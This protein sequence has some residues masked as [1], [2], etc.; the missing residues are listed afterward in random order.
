ME[1]L[2]LIDVAEP[3]RIAA[4][5]EAPESFSFR[6]DAAE[7]LDGLVP[8]IGLTGTYPYRSVY[9]PRSFARAGLPATLTH[10]F[11]DTLDGSDDHTG[12]RW[13]GVVMYD[14]HGS[15][16]RLEITL[17]ADPIGCMV[18]FRH[19]N[20]RHL[21]VLDRPV[22]FMGEMEVLRISGS[23]DA[24][25]RLEH[26]VLLKER[27]AAT[28]YQ[29]R[30]GRLTARL[31]RRPDG[32]FAVAVDAI[33]RPAA[34]CCVTVLHGA[35]GAVVGSAQ[36]DEH[37]SL[38]A[39]DLEPVP[40]PPAAGYRARIV[41]DLVLEES[42]WQRA[43]IRYRFG[44][45]DA[46]GTPHLR[47]TIR[48]HVYR[49]R[50]ALRIVHR[51]EVTSPHLPP[52]PG[53]TA[54]A[55]P[56]HAPAIRRAIAGSDGE[57][58]TLL[59]LR[60]GTL[61]ISRGA[62]GAVYWPG[63]AADGTPVAEASAVRLIHDHDQGH[64]VE[65]GD[66]VREVESRVSGHVT[67]TAG[68][69][70]GPEGESLTVALRRF[71]QT[72]PRAVRVSGDEI[73]VELLPPPAPPSP[74]PGDEESWHRIYFWLGEQ[75]YLLKAGMALSSEILLAWGPRDEALLAWFE[76]PPAVRPTLEWL[77]ACNALAPLAAKDTGV[78]DR[79]ERALDAGYEQWIADREIRRQYGWLNFGDWYGESAWSWGNNE[80]D[81]PFAHYC[82]FLRGG[83]PRWFI[84]GAEA[85][86]HLTDVDT[87]NFSTDATQVGA[88]Y[89]HMPGHA[90]GYLPPYFRS[91]M[92][93]SSSVPSHTWVEGSV[94]HYLLTGDE[95]LRESLDRTAQWLIASGLKDY[96][97]GIQHYDFANCRECGW[98]LIH[99]T[100][101]ARMSAAPRYLN[102]AALIV[103]RV[104]TLR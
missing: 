100:A 43:V 13:I 48:V 18:P 1:Q 78:L 35:S 97:G 36:E 26:V 102:A 28:S 64:R 68:A 57:Q 86:R 104:S 103:E 8:D 33:S 71:W 59:T 62:N 4:L 46:D 41:H 34:R 54:A 51:L 3:D 77:N 30:I 23:G 9:R 42:G 52:A 81:P 63:G 6:A 95:N 14:E 79:Y 32:G 94:L 60:S 10:R 70:P 66:A 73:A 91:K 7:N 87:V 12:R 53:G 75:G 61:G 27:P 80:Y 39:I 45:L 20:R 96:A 67:V 55:I 24:G 98:H 89:T 25:Y 22:Q 21:Y 19:D 17:G 15:D 65:T 44:H 37:L 72:Y 101:L 83:D 99:L 76:E 69:I 16:C 50:Q 38:H 29:P 11:W 88:Q 5:T 31:R 56:E 2:P 90:G 93:G 40:A 47:S 85:A 92:R 49:G 74:R 84:L 58:A 82:E